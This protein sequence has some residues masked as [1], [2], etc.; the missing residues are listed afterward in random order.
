MTTMLHVFNEHAQTL[1]SSHKSF[2]LIKHMIM[3]NVSKPWV[4]KAESVVLP[5]KAQVCVE[6]F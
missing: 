5:Y 2:P 1:E 4:S 3:A 6:A